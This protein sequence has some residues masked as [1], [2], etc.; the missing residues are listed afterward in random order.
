[1]LQNQNLKYLVLLR[2]PRSDPLLSHY[3]EVH[4]SIV[5]FGSEGLGERNV[6]TEKL[7]F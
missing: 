1:M 7:T 3:K 6:Q 4:K 5:D 2:Y